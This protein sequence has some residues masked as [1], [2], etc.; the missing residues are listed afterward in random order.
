MSEPGYRP[1]DFEDGEVA[2]VYGPNPN[3]RVWLQIEVGPPDFER[4]MALARQRGLDA[5]DLAREFIR[6]GLTRSTAATSPTSSRS[7]SNRR[8]A[9]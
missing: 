2:G 3:V 9:G 4:L 7:R 8:A 1:E 6:D 5:L